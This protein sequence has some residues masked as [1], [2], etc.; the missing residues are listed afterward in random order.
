MLNLKLIQCNE[1]VNEYSQKNCLK[2]KYLMKR[3]TWWPHIKLHIIIFQVL[4]PP[5]S[6]WT[7]PCSGCT[8]FPRDTSWANSITS[9]S[10][11]HWINPFHKFWVTASVVIC[12]VSLNTANQPLLSFT[13]IYKMKNMIEDLENFFALLFVNPADQFYLNSS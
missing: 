11:I 10:R 2:F 6:S 8:W 13:S 4:S 1:I 9:T 3:S 12:D 5:L 7:A